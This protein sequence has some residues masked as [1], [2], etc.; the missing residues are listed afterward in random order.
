MDDKNDVLHGT[1][2]GGHWFILEPEESVDIYEDLL[3]E[4]NFEES[5]VD[6]IAG[7]PRDYE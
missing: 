6:G 2:G 1:L 4:R 7:N 5:L 3:R